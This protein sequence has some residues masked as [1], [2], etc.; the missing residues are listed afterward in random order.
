MAGMSLR[1]LV[2]HP[3]QPDKALGYTPLCHSGENR[4]G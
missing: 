1:D 3:A 4:E 2:F